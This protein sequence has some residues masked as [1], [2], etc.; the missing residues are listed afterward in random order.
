M[1]IG[2]LATAVLLG[3][4]HAIEPDHVA[5]IVGLAGDASR[6]RAALVG[7]CFAAGHAAL[8][9]CWLGV[10]TLVLDSFPAVASSVG[11]TALGAVLLVTAGLV[12][13]DAYRALRADGHGH[14]HAGPLRVRADGGTARLLA[15]GVVGALFTLSP[16]VTMLGFVTGVLPTAGAAGAWLAVGA[17]T[18]AIVVAMATVGVA[19]STAVRWLDTRSTRL[20]VAGKLTAA[21]ALAV[22][23]VVTL[24]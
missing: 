3:A 5:G 9:V 12:A 17:Y 15:F 7:A 22:L 21:I 16:P 8:V 18:V 2:L 24:A 4:T 14:S 10:A 23:G 19:G 6:S 11:D 20:A 13:F 1:D